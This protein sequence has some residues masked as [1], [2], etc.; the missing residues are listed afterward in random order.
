MKV[1][2]SWGSALWTK[3]VVS[4]GFFKLS[5]HW[6][7]GHCLNVVADKQGVAAVHVHSDWWSA[8]WREVPL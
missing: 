2:D 1:E 3:E 4:D 5:N 8:M 7:A 6:R